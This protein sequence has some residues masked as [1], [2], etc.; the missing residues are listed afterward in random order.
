MGIQGGDQRG[1]QGQSGMMGQRPPQFNQHI[2]AAR[3]EN[4][5]K[6]QQLRQT[7]E[8]AQQQELKFKSQLEMF[9]H[10]QIQQLQQTLEQAQ[11]QENHFQAQQAQM[12]QEQQ[13]QLRAQLQQMQ[14]RHMAP[15]NSQQQPGVNPQQPISNPQQQRMMRPGIS[16]NPGLRHLLQQ[17]QYRQQV[18]GMQQQMPRSQGNPQQPTQPFD[19][20]SSFENFLN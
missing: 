1:Q 9:N 18:L 7:L 3:K 15:Q 10:M 17:P 20:V 4:L 5:A 13:K 2:E 12:E 14:Q 8:L 6:I 16:N 11:Q 19:D